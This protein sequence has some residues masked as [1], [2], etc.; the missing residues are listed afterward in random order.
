M[1]D[2]PADLLT[3]PQV[4]TSIQ[5]GSEQMRIGIFS[6]SL[7]FFWYMNYCPVFLY[8]NT[9]GSSDPFGSRPT[10]FDNHF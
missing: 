10:T 3:L 9:A 7:E 4:G 8:G 1:E 2:I 6:S 5:C